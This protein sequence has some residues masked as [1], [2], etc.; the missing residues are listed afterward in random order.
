MPNALLSRIFMLISDTPTGQPQ[1]H[2]VLWTHRDIVTHVAFRAGQFELPAR[3]NGSKRNTHLIIGERRAQSRA[4][5][6][7]ERQE[8]ERSIRP[9]DKSFRDEPVG[10]RIDRR[11]LVDGADP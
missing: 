3:H 11:V 2:A 5:A 1:A 4:G 8:L 6:P 10:F 9:A 7:A